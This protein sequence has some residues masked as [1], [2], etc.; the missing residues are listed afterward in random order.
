MNLT[1]VET[2]HFFYNPHATVEDQ[3]DIFDAESYQKFKESK[4]ATKIYMTSRRTIGK[5]AFNNIPI[6]MYPQTVI[7]K[8][9]EAVT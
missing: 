3:I 1:E 8:G 6:L 5:E 2:Y 4:N 9:F 7:R